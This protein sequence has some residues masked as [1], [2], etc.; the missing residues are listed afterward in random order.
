MNTTR[1]LLTLILAFFLIQVNAQNRKAEE[2]YNKGKEAYDD[3]NY[4]AAKMNFEKAL[5]HEENYDYALY[6]LA[7]SYYYSDEE[8]M[9]AETFEKLATHHPDF[10]SYFYYYWGMSLIYAGDPEKAAIQLQKG[11]EK[12]PRDAD[13]IRDHHEMKYLLDYCERSVAV[14]ERLATMEEPVNMGSEINSEWDEYM[15]M[16]NP[17]GRI[18]YY[19]SDKQGGFDNPDRERFEDY[20]DDIYYVEKTA[21][22]WGPSQLLPQPINSYENDGTASFSGDG[23]VMVY[24]GC[25]RDDGVG[26]CDIYIAYLEG[27]DW[28]APV[29]MGDVVNDESWDSQPCISSDGNSIFF[30][31]TRNGSHGS[32][33]IYITRKNKFGDWGLPVNLG[34]E[35]NTPLSE[36]S[37]YLSPD[38]KTLYFASAGHPGFGDLD[39]FMS[40]YEDCK[41]SEP[42]NL[43]KPL[44]STGEDEF[45]S[46]GGS[47]EIAYFATDREGSHGGSDIYTIPIPEEMRPKPTVVVTGIVSNAKKQEPVGAWVLIE[48]I[49]T[50]EMISVNKSNSE[51]GKYLVVL[52]S[53][54]NY[55]VTANKEGY[56]F[57]S[58]LFEVDKDIQYQE[59]EKNIELKPIEKGARV[60]LNNIFFETGKAELT[61]ESRLELD[62]AVDLI[63]ANPT[64]V[65][66]VGGN[67]DNVGNDDYNMSLSHERAKSVRQ[68]LVEAGTQP[69]RIQ[70]KGYG[71]TNPVADNETDEGR[72]A[73]RRTEF[74]ILEF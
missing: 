30:I 68:F 69:E 59:I 43:G 64:M 48:D 2:F 66:E 38:G 21:S 37:P 29:N 40:V 8:A 65:I 19:T 36:V 55:S 56:F 26:S 13:N 53:G 17:T 11:L 42:V 16:I 35:I 62:K 1:F 50:G 61:P 3:D 72:A 70:A 73:N 51:T 4:L 20:G 57:Y 45:F 24:A 58:Q 28:S 6:Y 34:D 25:N 10:W 60:V 27:N 52:P 71:E 12:Y 22:G 33:D 5:I 39:V 7:L 54:R 32:S 46:I 9:A 41:W 15:P 18:L 47:G 74:I 44:N 63:R 14:R 31:S 49:N 23:Q 67:T